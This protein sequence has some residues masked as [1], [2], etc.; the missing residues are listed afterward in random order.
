MSTVPAEEPT[1]V[2]PRSTEPTKD[3]AP[4][5]TSKAV[6]ISKHVHDHLGQL[7]PTPEPALKK[8]KD[9]IHCKPPTVPTYRKYS[10][11]L[12][13]SIE[14]GRAILWQERMVDYLQDL[15]ITVCNPRRGN[16]D[17]TTTPREKDEAF[18]LQVQWELS[19]LEH[20]SV[21][22]F[23][24]D[25]ATTSPVTM[26]ELGLWAKSGKVVVCC[27]KDFHKAGN[28]HITCRRYGIEFVERFEDLVEL[29]KK[30]LEKKGM[31]LNQDNDVVD[32]N[33]N[34]VENKGAVVTD[35]K[36][37]HTGIV[38]RDDDR[39]VDQ[40]KEST[41]TAR[42]DK[43]AQEAVPKTLSS[44]KKASRLAGFLGKIKGHHRYP[45][46]SKS[47]NEL[48]CSTLRL[49][50]PES[51]SN[52]PVL[53]TRT[54][55]RCSLTLINMPCCGNE[56]LLLLRPEP[57]VVPSSNIAARLASTA[58][59][60]VCVRTTIRAA[61]LWK[62]WIKS[63]PQLFDPEVDVENPQ[64]RLWDPPISDSRK[65]PRSP[66]KPT[67]RLQPSTM[68]ATCVRPPATGTDHPIK[69]PAAPPVRRQLW[70]MSQ[71]KG[72]L[73]SLLDY[74]YN[75]D[76]HSHVHAIGPQITVVVLQDAF[77]G[78]DNSGIVNL[79][80][81]QDWA[82]TASLLPNTSEHFFQTVKDDVT[83]TT[84]DDTRD[85]LYEA[86]AALYYNSVIALVLKVCP[87]LQFLCVPFTWLPY[88]EGGQ[89][90]G[91]EVV[92]LEG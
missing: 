38:I 85:A 62:C 75:V 77:D 6:D 59:S 91:V 28:V 90:G 52:D 41:T 30:M 48:L 18:N 65:V 13:G 54:L 49:R 37:I 43:S 86:P 26:L 67:T 40:S 46:E 32:E 64:R 74:L 24:F 58:E 47:L 84:F 70:W 81:D 27:D 44:P 10:V 60:S 39:E 2:D 19:A 68:A 17:T 22:C 11:F 92:G 50:A 3:K 7:P 33:G 55:I 82:T 83:L 88:V 61:Q 80:Y 35:F 66:A 69:P 1:T 76:P 79:L 89:L 29:I 5:T 9:F 14:M 87:N 51:V 23:F 71:R 21:I 45:Y 42:V 31:R 12:A 63:L 57:V 72:H 36:D 73:A 4:A 53:L 15:P 8:H 16:W 34:L 56:V 25:K 78:I 20:V